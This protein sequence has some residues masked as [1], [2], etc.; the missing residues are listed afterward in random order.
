MLNTDTPH[1]S[2]TSV[3]EVKD[4]LLGSDADMVASSM[5][6]GGGKGSYRGY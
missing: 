1:H 3:W 6:H 5:S 2:K 4:P